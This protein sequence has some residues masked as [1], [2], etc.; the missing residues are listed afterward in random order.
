MGRLVL[1]S[2]SDGGSLLRV[3]FLT[4]SERLPVGERL[5]SAP[6]I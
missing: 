2:F 5:E 1:Q 3:R 6:A 4:G